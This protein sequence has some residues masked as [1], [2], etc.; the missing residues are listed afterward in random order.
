LIINSIQSLLNR[1]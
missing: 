1:V